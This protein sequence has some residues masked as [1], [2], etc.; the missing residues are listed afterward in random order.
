MGSLLQTR[1]RDS[2]IPILGRLS[3]SL[4]RHVEYDIFFAFRH[5][6]STAAITPGRPW[7]DDEMQAVLLA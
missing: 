7:K 1:N 2:G 4:L 3:T 5:P 6:R